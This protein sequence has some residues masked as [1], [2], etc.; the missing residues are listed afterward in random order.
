M[1]EEPTRGPGFARA[2][3]FLLGFIA[4]ALAVAAMKLTASVV[5][6]FVIAVL[7]TFVLEPVV[8]ALERIKIPRA[9]GAIVVVLLIAAG[10]YGVGIILFSSVKAILT[11]YPK[12]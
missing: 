7:L 12:Y 9:I 10:V 11:L 2:N 1:P 8:I 4:F 5:I 6:P 3:L